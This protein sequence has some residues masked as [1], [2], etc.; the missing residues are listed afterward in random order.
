MKTEWKRIVPGLYRC[1][2]FEIELI[3]GLWHCRINNRPF[4]AARTLREA[5]KYCR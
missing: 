5:K 1:G 3:D 2:Q 4:D